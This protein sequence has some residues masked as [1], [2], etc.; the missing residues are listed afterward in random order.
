MRSA[1]RRESRKCSSRVPQLGFRRLE[2]DDLQQVFLWLLKPHVTKWYAPEPGSFMEVAAKYGPRTEEGNPV[3]A[4]IVVLDGED[5]G[6]IQTYAIE[7]FPDY[8]AALGGGAGEASVDLFIGEERCLNRGLGPRI[9]RRF[10][11]EIVFAQNNAQACLAGPAEGDLAA[12]RAFE[13]AGFRRWKTV[14]IEEREP[15]CVLRL[16]RGAPRFRIEPIDLERHL[17]TCVAFRRESFVAS[18]GSSAG[19]EEEMG[20][21]EESY[22]RQL[23]GRMAEVPEGNAHLWEEG[24]IVGQTEMRLVPGDPSVGYVNLFYVVPECRGRGLGRMLHEHAASVFRARGMQRMRLSVSTQNAMAIGFYRKLGWV[25]VGTRPNR[26]R[27]E[28]L[29]FA[30]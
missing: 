21:N 15:E 12:I 6:Y 9:V 8:E 28:I 4:F 5:I 13:K 11:D 19:I 26:E 22:L 16:E 2:V 7:V 24:R 10:V 29:E 3:Q 23:R 18:F 30:L 20:E 27:M 25:S 1:P 14:R 17:A